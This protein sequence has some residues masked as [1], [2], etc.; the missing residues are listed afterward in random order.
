MTMT[1]L[2]LALVLGAPVEA[3]RDA[4][5]FPSVGAC[6]VR[7]LDV[8][9]QG[10]I[11]STRT[12]SGSRTPAMVFRGRVAQRPEGNP[13]LLFDVF[14]PQGQRYQVLLGTATRRPLVVHG[15]TRRLD[16]PVEAR[17]AVAGSSIAWTSMYGSW[18][19]EPR[20]EGHD[21]PCGRADAF[22]I[23]P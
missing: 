5:L 11:V 17:L 2:L 18:R 12:A 7:V 10:R 14:N 22:T 1:T 16:R 15:G 6:S 9:A 21:R 20:F 23:L 4:G 13:P 8:D 19:V 3:H